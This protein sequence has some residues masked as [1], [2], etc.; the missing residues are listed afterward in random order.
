MFLLLSY[1][2]SRTVIYFQEASKHL[3]SLRQLFLHCRFSST[4]DVLDDLMHSLPRHLNMLQSDIDHK[5]E[6]EANMS[7]IMTTS[8]LQQ[9][10]GILQPHEQSFL[11][12]GLLGGISNLLDGGGS[13]NATHSSDPRVFMNTTTPSS[14]FICGSQGSG[15]SHTLSCLLE[16]CLIPST[17]STLPKPLVGLVFHFDNFMNDLQG[18]P[19]EAAFLASDPAVTVKVLCSPTNVETMKVLW[20]HAID[21]CQ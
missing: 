20:Q 17:V 19:C 15:K 13:S 21:G 1:Y 8:V 9:L 11:Q 2:S 18:S 14:T 7:A 4:M 16:N 3:R 5:E 12:Y 6:E 10:L